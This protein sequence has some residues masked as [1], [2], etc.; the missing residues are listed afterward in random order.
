MVDFIALLCY[1]D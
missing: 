1:Y